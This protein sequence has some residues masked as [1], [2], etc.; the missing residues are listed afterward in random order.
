M[1]T[2]AMERFTIR[3]VMARSLLMVI[4]GMLAFASIGSGLI[5]PASAQGS[6]ATPAVQMTPEDV[7]AHVAPAVV[8]VLNLQTTQD[9]RTGQAST[10]PQ[11][12]GTGFIIDAEGHIVTNW[13]VVT[14]GE[15]FAV[16]LF[17]GTQLD[18]E[19]VGS[20]PRDD[21]AVV[22]IDPASVPAVVSFG[23]SDELRPGQTILAIGSPLGA[24]TNTVTVGVVSA[25][26]RNML[27]SGGACQNYSNLIQHDAAINPGNS[28]GPLFNLKGE[29]VGVNTLGIPTDNAGQPVQGLFFAVPSSTVTQAVKQLIE[30]GTIVQPYI[31]VSFV[32][33]DPTVATQYNLPAENGI[34]VTNVTTGGP[35]AAAGLMVDDIV[36]AI[37]GQE[38]SVDK[39][40]AD[41][42]FNYAPGDTVTLTVLRNGQEISVDLTLE[43]APQA[44]FEQC[45]LQGQ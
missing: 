34:Y 26:G 1:E 27:G 35:A 9:I 8:T 24:F 22:K 39:S 15:Q 16:I 6:V 36:T 42:L 20:D 40:L 21:L 28:G 4:A 5:I 10:Q 33:I 2:F 31:G 18:A 41:I 37:D 14:G 23:S 25:V 3:P 45:A 30:T 7:V 44:L 11:G 17:D 43:Q 29:V 38:I 32:P 12:A 13:H 19:L